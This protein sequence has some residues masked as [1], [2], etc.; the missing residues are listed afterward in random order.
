MVGAAKPARFLR[1]RATSHLLLDVPRRAYHKKKHDRCF[2]NNE[3][4]TRMH[5][6]KALTPKICLVVEVDLGVPVMHLIC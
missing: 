5:V 1:P 3:L 4:Y 2:D 6:C